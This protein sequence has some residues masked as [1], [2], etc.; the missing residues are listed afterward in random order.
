MIVSRMLV[1]LVIGQVIVGPAMAGNGDDGK[2]EDLESGVASQ[3][4]NLIELE[5]LYRE[6]A[7]ALSQARSGNQ[8]VLSSIGGL[9]DR[10]EEVGLALGAMA[11]QIDGM[12]ASDAGRLSALRQDIDLLTT[13]NA[14]LSDKI[15]EL[16]K[17]NSPPPAAPL[18]QIDAGEATDPISRGI[19]GIASILIILSQEMRGSI[20]DVSSAVGGGLGTLARLGEGVDGAGRLE[21]LPG[22]GLVATV[23]IMLLV[24][25]LGSM[26]MQGYYREGFE[27]NFAI[28]GRLEAMVRRTGRVEDQTEIITGI[29]EPFWD[30]VPKEDPVPVEETPPVESRSLSGAD[31]EYARMLRK[32]GYDDE[33]LEVVSPRKAMASLQPP[34]KIEGRPLA[35]TGTDAHGRV[36]GRTQDFLEPPRWLYR[37][38]VN[39]LIIAGN[40]SRERRI[41]ARRKAR[42]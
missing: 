12:E 40:R 14:V 21:V 32:L 20:L 23:L 19:N 25:A 16:R 18:D 26:L 7:D 1:M 15:E 30:A 17:A 27:G 31:E 38:I 24:V 37:R 28:L 33:A 11:T 35:E 6:L 42:E 10:L 3:A 4:M 22:P 39:S 2:L 9:S 5:K 8:D 29:E 41:R 36:E 34:E 13:Q